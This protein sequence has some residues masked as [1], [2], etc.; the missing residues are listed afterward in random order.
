MLEENLF[1]ITQVE[2]NS[3]FLHSNELMVM[4]AAQQVVCG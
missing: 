2:K 1:L 4:H 3:L